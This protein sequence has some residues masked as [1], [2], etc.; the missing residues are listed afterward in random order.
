MVNVW[1]FISGVTV[2]VVAPMQSTLVCIKISSSTTSTCLDGVNVSRTS[3]IMH[4]NA[5]EKPAEKH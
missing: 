4:R 2:D 5:Y 1:P 3:S